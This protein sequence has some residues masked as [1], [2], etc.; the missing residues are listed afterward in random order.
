MD[1]KTAIFYIF[2]LVTV[3][4]ASRV[5]T[6]RNPVHSVLFLV[7][8]FVSAAAIWLLLQAEF[9]AIDDYLQEY[10]GRM[11]DALRSRARAIAGKL[12]AAAD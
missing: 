4:A 5:I 6:A 3:F 7:L 1:A 10:G 11:P 8:T 2:A 12:E 9:V